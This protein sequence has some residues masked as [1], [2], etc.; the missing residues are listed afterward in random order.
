[1]RCFYIEAGI[2]T[3]FAHYVYDASGV[4]T[5]KLVIDQFGNYES[6]TYIDGMFEY[7]KKVSDSGTTIKE[8]NYLR[9]QGGIE[10]R[11]GGYAGIDDSVPDTL[12]TITDYLSSAT[13]RLKVDAGIY[14]KEEY[15][16]YGES[17]LRT[18]GLKR[19]RF[20]GKEYDNESGLYYMNARYYCSSTAKFLSVDPLACQYAHQSSYCYADCNPIAK[21]D[22]SGMNGNPKTGTNTTSSAN[23]VNSKGSKSTKDKVLPASAES[24]SKSSGNTLL[25]SVVE[26]DTMTQLAKKYGTTV[27][28]IRQA[29][30][31]TQSRKQADQINVGEKLKMPS[32]QAGPTYSYSWSTTEVPNTSYNVVSLTANNAA[33][34]DTDTVVEGPPLYDVIESTMS[35][36]FVAFG[37]WLEDNVHIP[38]DPF[39][40]VG[41]KLEGEM[42]INLPGLEINVAVNLNY[43]EK[44]EG[45]GEFERGFEITT[46]ENVQ[47]AVS[48]FEGKYLTFEGTAGF[49][50]DVKGKSDNPNWF[51]A[52]SFDYI[53]AEYN[54]QER[55][56]F[57]GVTTERVGVDF[58]VSQKVV[59]VKW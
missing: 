4:R 46:K 59:D 51:V 17:S 26:G 15:Y 32:T 9:I 35:A 40:K 28:A 48:F 38:K 2:I 7:H 24:K 54:S 33:V 30:P 20:T 53:K 27:D 39:D 19:Y 8:K 42:A 25:H 10:V 50:F 55:E 18:V 5:K 43:F 36:P 37:E 13:I 34:T 49:V 29:N 44:V 11:V 3:K 23:N 45:Q 57:L 21:N 22:P 58:G 12:Y 14:D 1:M 52:G 31:Q 47:S 16:P 41:V 6:I 56:L